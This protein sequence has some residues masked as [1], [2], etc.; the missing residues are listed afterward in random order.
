VRFYGQLGAAVVPASFV[1][2]I[3]SRQL[4]FDT[5]LGLLLVLAFVGGVSGVVTSGPIEYRSVK[6]ST[7]TP[8]PL[9]SQRQTRQ[10]LRVQKHTTTL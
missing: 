6:Q 4:S 8:T 3:A 2:F 10:L 5:G 7:T 1:T 9:Y